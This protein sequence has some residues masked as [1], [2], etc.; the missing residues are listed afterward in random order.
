MKKFES[1]GEIKR[2]DPTS[3]EMRSI[4]MIAI[5]DARL[6]N[7]RPYL[8]DRLRSVPD[9]YRQWRI[10]ETAVCKVVDG[11]YDTLPVKTLMRMRTLHNNGEV[12]IR[13]MGGMNKDSDCMIVLTED[14][15]RLVN[16]VIDSECSMCMKTGKDIKRCKLHETLVRVT[17]P[18]KI[19][20]G[21]SVLCEYTKIYEN[22]KEK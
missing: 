16:A 22:E 13:P 3:R 12:I 19:F 10:A 14:L 1:T 21:D 5:L 2:C 8:E 17:P 4:E 18:T 11:L 7:D 6:A 20:D 15:K 9:L